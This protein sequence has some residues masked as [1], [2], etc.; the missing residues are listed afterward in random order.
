MKKSLLKKICFIV[1]LFIVFLPI[2]KNETK[3]KVDAIVLKNNNNL[4]VFDYDKLK[5]SYIFDYNDKLSK[6]YLYYD[7]MKQNKSDYAYRDDRNGYI[8]SKDVKFAYAMWNNTGKEFNLNDYTKSEQAKKKFRSLRGKVN[9]I[10]TNIDGDL[11]IKCY[12]FDVKSIF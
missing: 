12:E 3:A 8:L 10:N 6:L 9:F 7:R 2:Y 5:I 1:L 4:Y 11:I